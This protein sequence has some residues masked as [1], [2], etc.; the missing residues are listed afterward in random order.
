MEIKDCQ[1][2][3]LLKNNNFDYNKYH[4]LYNLEIASENI[5]KRNYKSYINTLKFWGYNIRKLSIIEKYNTCDVAMRMLYNIYIK[6]TIT[7][8]M[9]LTDEIKEYYNKLLDKYFPN[10]LLW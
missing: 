4:L 9:F 5:S 1:Y 6:L 10:E 7:D 8:N 3:Y 2:N